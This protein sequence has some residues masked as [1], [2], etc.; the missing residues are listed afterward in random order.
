VTA[1]KEEEKL[2]VKKA[3]FARLVMA[4]KC[5]ILKNEGHIWTIL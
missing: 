5:F 1:R 4:L 3:E 2:V